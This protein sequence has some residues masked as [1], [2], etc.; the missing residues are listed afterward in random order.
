MRL[1]ETD[2]ATVCSDIFSKYLGTVCS[3][4]II[5]VLLGEISLVIVFATMC[6]ETFFFFF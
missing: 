6:N 3:E 4:L 2:C 1:L 5:I